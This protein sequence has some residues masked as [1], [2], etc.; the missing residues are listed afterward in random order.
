MCPNIE[1]ALTLGPS[2]LAIDGVLIIGEHGDYPAN[3]KGQDLYPRK[4]FF[5]AA[6]EVIRRSGRSVPIFV[7]KHLSHSWQEAKEMVA[8]AKRLNIPLMTGSSLPGTWRRPAI[9]VPSGT[10]LQEI[11][12]TSYHTL[13]GYGFHG[14]ETLQCIA[15]RRVGG[16]VGVRRVQCL[17]GAAVWEAGKTGR[18]DR[19]LLDAA[20]AR[21]PGFDVNK[22]EALVPKPTVFLIEYLDGLKASLFTLNPAVPAWAIAWRTAGKPEPQ[23]TLFWTQEARP[24]GHFTFLMRGIAKMMQS[25]KP[26]RPLDRTLLTTGLM[27]F[28]LTSRLQ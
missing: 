26:T 15:E 19:S 13:Y 21:V 8:V 25:G 6:V 5:D 4:R 24:L 14:L 9:E 10:R 12:A 22:V 20:L 7:D 2:K 28:L 27:D 23:S 16:E 11:V 1:E 18:Y 17:E 3:E